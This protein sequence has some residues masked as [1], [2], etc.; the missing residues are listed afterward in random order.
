MSFDSNIANIDKLIIL[1]RT[2]TKFIRGLWIRLFLRE[3]H[4]LLLVGQHV[5]ISHAHNVRC[6]KNVKFEDY[7]EIQGLC[8]N[9]LNFGNDVTIGRA[10]MIRPSSYYGGD[11]GYGITIGDNSSI[12]PH[13]YIG[14]SGRIYIG[15]NVMIGPKCSLFAENHVFSNSNESIKSQGVQQRGITIG[16]D[17]WIGSNVVILDGVSIG[18]HVVIGAGT[19]IAKDVP[20]YSII[21]DK[22]DRMTRQRIK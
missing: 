1:M 3:A 20:D 9:G 17:C 22:R 4:G 21:L 15:N 12:G 18:S 6:G 5:T 16:D 11:Y 10:T 13:G 14:C 2:G 19:L 8:S 7:A